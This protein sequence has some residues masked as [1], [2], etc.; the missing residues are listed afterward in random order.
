MTTIFLNTLKRI[1]K[2]PV[3]WIFI[4]L[5]PLIFAVLTTLSTQSGDAGDGNGAIDA[6]N[7]V[8]YFGVADQDD[9]ALSRTLMKQLRLRYNIIEMAEADIT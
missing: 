1:L 5:F 2:Q 6:T 7:T 9:S 8:M 3:N 4:L